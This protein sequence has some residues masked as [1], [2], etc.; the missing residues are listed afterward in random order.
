M[1]EIYLVV[2][3]GRD[4]YHGHLSVLSWSED[5]KV[6]QHE[7]K[8]LGF[9][10]VTCQCGHRYHYDVMSVRKLQNVVPGPCPECGHTGVFAHKDQPAHVQCT[11]CG[12]TRLEV[13]WPEAAKRG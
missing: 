4:D 13:D 1:N 10:Q 7:V 3:D 2:S 11:A 5:L 8:R 12:F 6:A 9:E